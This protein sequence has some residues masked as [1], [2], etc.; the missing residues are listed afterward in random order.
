MKNEQCPKTGKLQQPKPTTH[1]SFK[2]SQCFIF[3]VWYYYNTLRQ[4]ETLNTQTLFTHI[5]VTYIVISKNSFENYLRLSLGAL[6]YITHGIPRVPGRQARKLTFH[7]RHL[8]DTEH[9]ILE[10]EEQCLLSNILLV[11]DSLYI[12]LSTVHCHP[13]KYKHGCC[14]RFAYQV[15]A[16]LLPC[17]RLNLLRPLLTVHTVVF[18]RRPCNSRWDC[19]SYERTIIA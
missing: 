14:K 11:R 7:P 1:H 10:E 4:I 6:G 18:C 13:S 19:S 8:R 9:Y 17:L 3:P 15:H 5:K 2:F 16:Q 12:S